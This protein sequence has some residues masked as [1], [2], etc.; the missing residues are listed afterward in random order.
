MANAFARSLRKN[1][2]PQEAKLWVKLRELKLLGYHFRRQ[3][4]IRR[5]IVDFVSFRDLLVIEVDGGQHNFDEATR[6]DEVRD[7]F[8][9]G[10]GFRVLRFWNFEVDRNLNGVMEVIATA[11]G[12]PTRPA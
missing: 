4:P 3:A 2:T 8:L 5:I 6:K 12:T 11:L 10:E 7:T 9:R 1:L